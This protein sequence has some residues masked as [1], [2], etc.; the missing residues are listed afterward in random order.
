MCEI[1]ETFG[2]RALKS[3]PFCRQQEVKV[4]QTACSKKT[5]TLSML[6]V[7]R[8]AIACC[9]DHAPP[10]TGVLALKVAANGT[11]TLDKQSLFEFTA[12]SYKMIDLKLFSRPGPA[13]LNQDLFLLLSS[14]SVF[15]VLVDIVVNIAP[16]GNCSAR[17]CKHYWD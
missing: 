16:Q 17:V 1:T 9:I 10:Q 3:V 8:A 11:C 2:V 5:P 12:A 7:S 15:L 13:S 6:K 4:Q 14:N